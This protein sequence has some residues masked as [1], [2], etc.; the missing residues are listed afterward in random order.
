MT[1]QGE[2]LARKMQAASRMRQLSSL[3]IPLL[4]AACVDVALEDREAELTRSPQTSGWEAAVDITIT[5]NDFG[6]RGCTASILSRHWLLT[7]AHCVDGIADG[8][9]VH[10]RDGLTLYD[11]PAH[12]VGHPDWGTWDTEDDV[13]LIRLDGAGLAQV[14]T[15]A[16]IYDGPLASGDEVTVIGFGLGTDPGGSEECG[17]GTSGT[18]R[19]Q[20]YN[21]TDVGWESVDFDYGDAEV[22]PGDSGGPWFPDFE[23]RSLV[24]AVTSARTLVNDASGSRIAAKAPWIKQTTAASLACPRFIVGPQTAY[25]ECFE[26]AQ[27]ARAVSTG[28]AHACAVLYDGRVRCWGAGTVGQRGDGSDADAVLPVTAELSPS[29]PGPAVKVAAGRDHTCAVTSAGRVS[30]WG[31]NS[32]GQLGN[33]TLAT[34]S[35]Q[36]YATGQVV[37]FA[38]G[39]PL[40]DVRSVSAGTAHT[41]AL[42]NGGRVYCWGDNTYGQLGN[43]ATSSSLQPALVGRYDD[44]ISTPT[45][46][47]VAFPP[48]RP[49]IPLENVEQLDAGHRH[50]CVIKTD[51]TAYC[52][53]YNAWGQ[54]GI[55][56]ATTSRRP[57]RAGTLTSVFRISAGYGHTCVTRGS[58]GDLVSCWG[59]N[60]LGQLGTGDATNRLSPVTIGVGTT[61]GAALEVSA[62]Q[63]HTCFTGSND[64]Q[65]CSGDNSRGALGAALAQVYYS[66]TDSI[67]E[68]DTTAPAAGEGFTC[69]RLDSGA[70][71]CAGAGTRGQLASGRTVDAPWFYN[72][73]DLHHLPDAIP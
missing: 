3:L 50:S 20:D 28:R 44:P 29:T 69:T 72:A 6:G 58:G 31:S 32:N 15:Q 60:A 39:T 63:Y 64:K 54:L 33:P 1:S 12:Y 48:P 52:W 38:S 66:L 4:C 45:T 35:G 55:G 5:T 7:A 21:L 71:S 59:M 25:W 2:G 49:F 26:S 16:G 56:S 73:R 10:V 67:I 14:T 41:C 11:G 30:C 57:L 9:D 46:G 8:N 18:K 17:N 36:H 23:G 27:G 70:V 61:L 42:T 47:L 65:R 13:G 43:D 22:C 37:A 34:G 62:G 24:A 53:G 68:Q 40:T 19:E 51:H